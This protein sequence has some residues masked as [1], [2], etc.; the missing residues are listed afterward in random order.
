MTAAFALALLL[1][2]PVELGSLFD[3]DALAALPSG[4]EP[5]SLL[6]TAEATVTAD[7]IE[8]GGLFLGT[9]A[10]LGVHGSSWTE[11]TWSLGDV[12]I[13]D[14]DRG[15]TPLL[16]LP[17]EA[18]ESITLKTALL[19]AA[20]GG[21]GAH[22]ALQPRTPG[23]EWHG[24]VGLRT[25]PSGLAGGGDGVAPP[26][27]SMRRWDD[28]AAVASGPIT[29]RLGLLAVARGT[30]GERAD[31]GAEAGLEAGARSLFAAL[32]FRPGP[33]DEWRLLAAAAAS[34]RPTEGRVRSIDPLAQ[35]EDRA[36][37]LQL[38][39]GR[40]GDTPWRAALAYQRATATPAESNVLFAEIERLRD[41]PA[42]ELY[43][44][45]RRRR[46][47]DAVVRVTPSALGFGGRNEATLG[48]AFERSSAEWSPAS[49]GLTFERVGGVPARIWDD[50]TL[51]ETR[52]HGTQ[53]AVFVDDR[54]GIGPVQLEL[55]LR[56]AR[57]S[58][59]SDTGSGRIAW[60]TASPRVASRWEPI[61]QVGLFA[62][63]ERVHPRLPLRHLQWSDPLA[64]QF[65]VYRWDDDGDGRPGLGDVGPLVSRLGPGADAVITGEVRSPWTDG[66]VV[67]I[68]ARPADGWWIRFTGIHR[69]SHGL[70]MA[71]EGGT[72]Y[73]TFLIPD[74]SVDIVGPADDQ[75]LPVYSR[76]P[77][78]FGD[79]YYGLAFIENH[80]VR[81]EG[82]ELLVEKRLARTLLVRVSGTASRS[83]GVGANRGYGPLENDPAVVG[84]SW[85][86]PNAG[87]YSE[88]RLFFDRAYTLK[89]AALWR[90]G[91]WSLGTVANYQDGQPFARMVIAPGLPQGAEAIQAISRGD[92]RF[93]YTL[94]WDAR[95][96]RAFG[97]GAARAALSVE[98][99]NLLDMQNEVEEDVVDGP[100]FRAVTATQ[101]P[102]AVRIGLT[103]SR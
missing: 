95:I 26:I 56:V 14:P 47:V 38:S 52:A 73:F 24:S 81:H 20:V 79:D 16:A 98:A 7:R 49:P 99:F 94:T 10:V 75:L 50:V 101:P 53:A 103:I 8:A 17:A 27:A 87:T 72:E 92:H 31:R 82:V 11:T 91:D 86:D 12:D 9:P 65:T 100:T 18:L 62:G 67:G 21:S 93:T 37:H 58:A 97:I 68:D 46:R 60:T 2:P 28:L 3:A 6:R 70:P 41:G 85:A 84:E 15:G 19:P 69:R 59:A 43:Q 66:V 45:D 25:T 33:Q 40:T 55:G 78:T 96:E 1:G 39:Y 61:R 88:G 76:D 48:L 4:R 23:E 51:G 13:T 30:R 64:P 102:R 54:V 57:W 42:P 36:A 80:G 34:E 5:W 29:P 74:P 32:T 71:I 63:W 22:V 35:D 89:V 44:G 77:A 90:P 83:N